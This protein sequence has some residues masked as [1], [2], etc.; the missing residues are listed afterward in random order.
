MNEQKL[1]KVEKRIVPEWGRGHIEWTKY[2]LALDLETVRL[3]V[4]ERYG[5]PQY[6]EYDREEVQYDFEELRFE[7]LNQRVENGDAVPSSDWG[8]W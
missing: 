6:Y 5:S 7:Q 1:F 3:T 8:D 4:H 2:F